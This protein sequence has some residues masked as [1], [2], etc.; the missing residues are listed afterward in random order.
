M[1][2]RNITTQ[3]WSRMAI[4]SLFDRGVLPDWKEFAQALRS[5]EA[6]AKET[7]LMCARHQERG[8]V[9]AARRLVA[10]FHPQLARS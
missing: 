10:H 3:E 2:H 6:L 9:E 7:L 8:S 1:E 4:D 5:D